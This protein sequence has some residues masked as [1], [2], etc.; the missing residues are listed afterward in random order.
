MTL[1]YRVTNN[2]G[3]NVTRLRYRVVDISTAIQPAGPTAD[4]RAL[5]PASMRSISV[6]LTTR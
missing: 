4:L 3:G 5:T 2:T 1:R 6:Q